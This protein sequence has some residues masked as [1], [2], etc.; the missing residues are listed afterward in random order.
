MLGYLFNILDFKTKKLQVLNELQIWIPNG[1]QNS[2]R[3]SDKYREMLC[4]LIIFYPN[5]VRKNVC[6][7]I[8]MLLEVRLD[9][10]VPQMN[11]IIDY[12]LLRTQVGLAPCSYEYCKAKHFYTNLFPH[13]FGL[14]FV[15]VA[16]RGERIEEFHCW[17]GRVKEKGEEELRRFS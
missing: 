5:Q 3:R 13:S 2:L 17:R 7:A 9:R 16:V 11:N 1:V 4:S 10:L 15:V 6:R 12:M 8:V 14:S